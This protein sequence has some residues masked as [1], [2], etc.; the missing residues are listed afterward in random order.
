[1]PGATTL[2]ARLLEREASSRPAVLGSVLLADE[3]R[4][5]V[6]VGRDHVTVRGDGPDTVVP[7]TWVSWVTTSRG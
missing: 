5:H 6:G 3:V 7:L 2:R 4:G 1:V